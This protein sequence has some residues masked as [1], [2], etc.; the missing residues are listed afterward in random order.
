MIRSKSFKTV[1]IKDKQMAILYFILLFALFYIFLSSAKFGYDCGFGLYCALVYYFKKRLKIFLSFGAAVLLT[2]QSMFI[3][4]SIGIPSIFI[5]IVVLL[6]KKFN[7]RITPIIL[8]LA[9]ILSRLTLFINNVNANDLVHFAVE[10]FLSAIFLMICIN[11]IKAPL[12]RGLK[13]LS[14]DETVCVAGV[15]LAFY[16]GL[17]SIYLFEFKLYLL[18]A[19]FT[20]L[21][22]LVVCSLSFTLSYSLIIGMAVCLLSGNPAYLGVYAVY[23]ITANIFKDTSKYLCAISIILIDL[24][25]AYYFKIFDS[26]TYFDLISLLS[27]CFLFL[28]LPKK[29]LKNLSAELGNKKQKQLSRHIINRT[30]AQ[31]NTKLCNVSEVFY[32]MEKIFCSMIKGYM[33]PDDAVKMLSGDAIEEVCGACPDKNNCHKKNIA[34]IEE[35]FSSAIKAGIDK[36][37]VTLLDIP[38]NIASVCVKTN[39]MLSVCN[40][41]SNSYRQYAIVI[42]N[43][44]TSRALIGR[45]FK[46]VGDI[47][48]QLA[49]ET[50]NS[51]GFDNKTERVIID[52]LAYNNIICQEA[53]VYNENNHCK[54]ISLLVKTADSFNKNIS[55][56]LTKLM[57]TKM[58]VSKRE[59]SK[60]PNLSVLHLK[61][62]PKFDVI[63]GAAGCAKEGK[64]I[65]G[66][67]HTLTRISDDKFLLALCDG[68]GSGEN[69]EKTSSMAISM[70]ENFYRAGFDSDT[71]L[72]G[73]NR[74]LNVGGEDN[75]AALDIC[76]ID[77]S[78]GIC[79]FI[80]LGSPEGFLKGKDNTVI[81]ESNALPIGILDEFTPSIT[82]KT[83]NSGDIIVLVSDGITEAFTDSEKLKEYIFSQNILNPQQL[84][85]NILKKALTFNDNI[86][87]D[88]M[89]VLTMRVYMQL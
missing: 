62:A 57:E 35:G 24:L 61:P 3:L 29:L 52:E 54:N 19:A 72:S 58:V 50:K 26:Y 22:S 39:S 13:N 6:F 11:A 33:S 15:V 67:T 85:E 45:Q 66:D 5:I 64:E 74:L 36:G 49:N 41:L 9:A 77:L 44:D 88:D 73:V 81:I 75:F 70:V 21:I 47:L 38:P 40:R 87:K 10:I 28:L 30:R 82:T 4:Y 46:G 55:K 34:I 83:V 14:I 80:K 78:K 20:I 23:A 59:E 69:A 65:S 27:G 7:K 18:V 56:I 53:V 79:D 84:S 17:Y 48:G 60:T 8:C 2:E 25:F 42:S 12:F 1:H 68:M 51:L 71:I 86:A 37:K 31:L 76:A 32:E 16:A 63:F 89:T 43:L